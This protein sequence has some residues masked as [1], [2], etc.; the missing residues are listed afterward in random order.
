MVLKDISF[1]NVARSNDPLP[2]SKLCGYKKKNL[3]GLHFGTVRCLELHNLTDWDKTA[4][5]VAEEKVLSDS[6]S[7]GE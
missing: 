7:D 2:G 4:E 5:L 6:S 3:D 1:G